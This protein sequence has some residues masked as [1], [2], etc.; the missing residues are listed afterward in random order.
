[1]A[2]VGDALLSLAEVSRSFVS[3]AET[4]WAVREANLTAHAGD[5]VCVF[6]ASGSGKSTL[7][8]VI[9]GLDSPD[10]GQ[11]VVDSH[12]MASLDE[13]A[14]ARLRLQTVG[15]VFQEHNLIEEF[16][17]LENVALPLEALGA[18]SKDASGLA[19]AQLARVG[20]AGLEDRLPSQLSGGQRQRV[21]IARA[22]VGDRRI[23]LAD[24]PTGS[25]DSKASLELFALLRA[26]CDDGT[27]AV[28]CSHDPRCR[29][30]ADAAYEMID[31]R[32]ASRS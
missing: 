7:I 5:F 27:V 32:L 3:E 18:S 1:M 8:N 21:G 13:N 20:L 6:G 29:E 14:R 24:E 4:V 15:V 19:A 2:S 16:T 10:C 9:A 26:L 12:E 25:L 23:L 28:V 31:G 11:I 30:F 22:L 17:A